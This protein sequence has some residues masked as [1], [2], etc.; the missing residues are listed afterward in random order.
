MPYIRTDHTTFETMKNMSLSKKPKE[1]FESILESKGGVTCLKK[2]GELPRNR[3]QIS[4]SKKHLK[5]I[6]EK[7]EL[8]VLMDR[9]TV[10]KLKPDNTFVFD[11]TTDPELILFIAEKT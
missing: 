1:I 2:P 6:D 4:D 3:Q 8:K 5:D 11:L 7:D 9:I 10:E